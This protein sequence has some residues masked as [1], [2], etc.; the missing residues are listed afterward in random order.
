MR[1]LFYDDDELAQRLEDT[2]SSIFLAGPTSRGCRTRWR[3]DAVELLDNRGFSGTVVIPEF[4]NRQ[5]D[6]AA[7]IRFARSD[8]PA[9]GMRPTSYG[10]LEWET[11][12]IERSTCVLFWMPFVPGSLPGLTTRAEV[13]RE[14]ARAPERIVLGMPPGELS[15]SHIRYHAHKGGVTIHET[16]PATVD[17]AL[18]HLSA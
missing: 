4:R 8:C 1:I 10:I 12:G 16:L 18:A 11:I 6:R 14:L 17:A 9:P 15:G 13:S 3:I 5:F 7:P 2:E